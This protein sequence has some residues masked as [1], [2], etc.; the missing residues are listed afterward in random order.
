MNK[1]KPPLCGDCKRQVFSLGSFTMRCG[2]YG[3]HLDDNGKELIRLAECVEN[4]GYEAETGQTI[5]KEVRMNDKPQ[6]ERRKALEPIYK[7]AEMHGMTV[8]TV[9]LEEE[10][11]ADREEQTQEE[12]K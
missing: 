7:F 1:K 12:E 5:G 6:D 8:H 4:D 11:E 3:E 2:K 10:A 9:T